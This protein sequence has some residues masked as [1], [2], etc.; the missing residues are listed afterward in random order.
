MT[1]D[2]AVTGDVQ[3]WDENSQRWRTVMTGDDRRKMFDD[4]FDRTETQFGGPR[5]LFTISFDG[6]DSGHWIKGAI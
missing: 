6:V 1:E 4:W 5:S 2:D 3:E